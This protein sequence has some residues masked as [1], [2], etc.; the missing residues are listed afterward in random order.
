M[1][2]STKFS[3]GAPFPDLAWPLTG[4][5]EL[6]VA[7]MPGWRVLVV[8]RGK[9]CPRCKTY[10]NTLNGLLEEFKAAGISVA[11]LSAESSMR[12]TTGCRFAARMPESRRRISRD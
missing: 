10:L 5:G 1:S 6:D 12:S 9:H 7:R 8:Y 2:K 4:G 11:A 3:A